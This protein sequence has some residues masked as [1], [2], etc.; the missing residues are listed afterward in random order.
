MAG[1]PSKE[2][3]YNRTAARTPMQW[4]AGRNAGFSRAAAG[5]LYLPV[6]AR[7]TRPNVAAQEKSGRSLLNTVRRLVALRREHPA[8]GADGA[9]VPLYAKKKQYPL[10]YLRRR[11]RQQVLVAVNPSA[12]PVRAAFRLPGEA[13]AAERLY[14]LGAKLAVQGTRVELDMPGVSSGVWRVT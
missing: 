4:S 13:V 2:G 14:A 3:G 12:T 8:L 6:D 11:G 7:K 10:A 5:K 1:L 9:F